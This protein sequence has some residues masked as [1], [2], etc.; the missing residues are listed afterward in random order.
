VLHWNFV[1]TNYL[2]EVMQEFSGYG[3]KGY[4]FLHFGDLALRIA[5][6]QT[7]ALQICKY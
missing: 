7:A 6:H 3:H 5:F 2:N 4:D 1:S